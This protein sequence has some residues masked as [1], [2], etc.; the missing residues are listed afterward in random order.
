[1]GPLCNKLSSVHDGRECARGTTQ[2]ILTCRC[3]KLSRIKDL[4][5]LAIAGVDR[6]SAVGE[7]LGSGR[8]PANAIL[9]KRLTEDET[10][11]WRL[12][13]YLKSMNC[14]VLTES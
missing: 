5:L 9:V 11:T 8:I 1:M 7:Y 4:L 3:T 12:W 6:L 2:A 13:Q 14:R 10:I